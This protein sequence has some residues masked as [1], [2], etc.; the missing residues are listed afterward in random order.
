MEDKS[1]SW[2]EYFADFP[3]FSPMQEERIRKIVRDEIAKGIYPSQFAQYLCD[4][5]HKAVGKRL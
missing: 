3:S 1:K 2:S 5:L 4:E